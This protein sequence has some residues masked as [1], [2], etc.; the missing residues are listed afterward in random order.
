MKKNLAI[1]LLIVLAI[2]VL[3]GCFGFGGDHVDLGPVSPYDYP[4]VGMWTWDAGDNY[5]YIFR[6]DGRGSRGTAPSLVQ[7]FE[8]EVYGDNNLSMEF[9]HMTELWTYSID[10]DVLTIASRQVRGMTYSYIRI[11]E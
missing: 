4:L 10:R 2:G 11:D 9:S 7:R 5:L 6:A 1:V 3:S 8:W